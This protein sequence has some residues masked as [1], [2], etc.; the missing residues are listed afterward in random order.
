MLFSVPEWYTKFCL[1]AFFLITECSV[2]QWFSNILSP[3]PPVCKKNSR[4]PPLHKIW[5]SHLIATM[6]S[7]V[8]A[9]KNYV[10]IKH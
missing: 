4:D 10:F 9:F 3:R 1:K 7:K 8:I 6:M 5:Q 2:G